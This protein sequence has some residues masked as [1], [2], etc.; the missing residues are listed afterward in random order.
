MENFPELFTK[1]LR[2]G[3]IRTKYIPEIV[4]YANNKNISDN[5][6]N[7]PN[8]YRE[9]DAIF[10]IN[11]EIQGFKSGEKY[12]FAI[13]K[14]ESEDFI[15]GIGLHI[16]KINNKAELGYWIAEPFWNNGFASEAGEEILNYGFNALKLNKI[17]AT[18][19]LFNPS[20][21]RVLQKIGMNKEA[22]LKAHY[23]KNEKYEDVGQY[24]L[25]KNEYKK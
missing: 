17:F 18:Y 3:K 6:L 21:E 23:L 10:W 12:I 14:K 25:L 11:M 16:D 22:D 19:F 9:E 24:Y 13:Y 7:L 15:G 1:R 8:P 4:K 5:T 2:L 20:S